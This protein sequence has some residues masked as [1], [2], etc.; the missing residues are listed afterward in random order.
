MTDY[1]R[2]GALELIAYALWIIAIALVFLTLKE[3]SR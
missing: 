1:R 2:D 3:Y